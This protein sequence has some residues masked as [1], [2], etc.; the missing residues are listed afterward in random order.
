MMPKI[1]VHLDSI[2][3]NNLGQL[4]AR[5]CDN[6]LLVEGLRFCLELLVID[7]HRHTSKI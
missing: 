2:T 5:L 6:M 4:E 1:V 3:F 7:F